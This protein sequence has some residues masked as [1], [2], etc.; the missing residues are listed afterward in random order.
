MKVGRARGVLT[1]ASQT[2]FPRCV[3]DTN[4]R[5]HGSRSAKS[6]KTKHQCIT[7]IGDHR[8]GK[9][10]QT[11]PAINGMGNAGGSPGHSRQTWIY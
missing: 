4:R 8:S 9:R 3:G 1:S 10:V 5:V 11:P 7:S 2:T 6:S